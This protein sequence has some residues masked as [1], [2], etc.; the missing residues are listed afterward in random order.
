MKRGELQGWL[1]EAARESRRSGFGDR[2]TKVP[3][4]AVPLTAVWPGISDFSALRIYVYV[5]CVHHILCLSHGII[6]KDR[7]S[8][9]AQ[10]LICRKCFNKW[11]TLWITPGKPSY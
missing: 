6:V 9:G 7:N 8:V 4:L 3:I 5:V 1:L 10:D 11:V 2:R